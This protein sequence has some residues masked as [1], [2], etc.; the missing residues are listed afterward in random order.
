M[1]WYS[2]HVLPRAVDVVLGSA[3]MGR[4]REPVLA[5]LT[6]TVVELGFGSGT[7]LPFYPAEVDRVLAVEPSATAFRLAARRVAASPVV[8]ELVGLDGGSLALP[9]EAADHAVSTW[10]MCSIPD[11]DSALREVRRVLRPGGTL[12]FL[13]H[14]LSPDPNV[15][16]WQHW[17]DPWQQRFAGGCHTTRDIPALIEGAGFEL[18]RLD[19]CTLGRPRYTGYVFSGRAVPGVGLSG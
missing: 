3:A 7:N 1:G 4:L 13:E 19:T 10:T 2:E 6:G 17:L 9:D 5:G 14:G 15:A 16:R 18:V 11:V 12:S 8:V